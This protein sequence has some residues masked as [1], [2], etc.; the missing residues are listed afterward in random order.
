MESEHWD[1]QLSVD[2]DMSRERVQM[3]KRTGITGSGRVAELHAKDTVT[4][5]GMYMQVHRHL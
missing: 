4:V 3:K 5:S 2:C 1:E